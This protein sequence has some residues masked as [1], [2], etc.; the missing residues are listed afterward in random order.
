MLVTSPSSS[1][2]TSTGD[3]QDVST[4]FKTR[5][6]AD[7]AGPLLRQLQLNH[8]TASEEDHSI[9]SLK[10]NSSTAILMETIPDAVEVLL[11]THGIT[12][13]LMVKCFC[14]NIPTLQLTAMFANMTQLKEWFKLCLEALV[15][16]VTLTTIKLTA[17]TT[18]QLT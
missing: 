11:S 10:S 2:E 15:V 4:L 5:A 1:T 8:L 13:K 14:Q 3:N 6:H 17:K 16:K 7:L 9:S 12:S 18:A